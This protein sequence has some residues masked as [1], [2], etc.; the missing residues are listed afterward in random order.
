VF[1]RVLRGENNL[2]QKAQSEAP[3]PKRRGFCLAAVLRG[4]EQTGQI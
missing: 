4:G 1:L 2:P 3:R